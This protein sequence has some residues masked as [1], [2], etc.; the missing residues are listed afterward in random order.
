M[1]LHRP[2][3][4]VNMVPGLIELADADDVRRQLGNVIHPREGPVLAVL[5]LH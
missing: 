4:D 3:L 5:P 2:F 1:D